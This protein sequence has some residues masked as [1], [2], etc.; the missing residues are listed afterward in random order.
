MGEFISGSGGNW[1]HYSSKSYDELALKISASAAGD[2]ALARKAQ[3]LL[4]EQDCA[5]IPLYFRKNSSLLASGWRGL[6]INPMNYVYLKTV[7]RMPAN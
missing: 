3:Q 5:V 1:G 2:S 4:L 7:R 6:A